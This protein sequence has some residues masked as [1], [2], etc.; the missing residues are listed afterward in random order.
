MGRTLL[1]PTVAGITAACIA[2]AWLGGCSSASGPPLPEKFEERSPVAG[3]HAGPPVDQ[4]QTGSARFVHALLDAYDAE[5]A[6]GVAAFLDGFYRAPASRGYEES[7]ERVLAALYGA[8]F[9]GEGGFD[10]AVARRPMAAA[11]WT[12]VSARLAAVAGEQAVREAVKRGMKRRPGDTREFEMMRFDE[13]R[14]LNRVMLPVGAPSC[15]LEGPLGLGLDGVEPG[16]VL[17]TDRPLRAVEQAAVEAGAIAIISDYVFPYCVDPT[18]EKRDYDAVFCDEVRAGSTIPSFQVSQRVGATLR[19]AAQVGTRVRLEAK[20][21][22]EERPLR[23][24]L[25]TIE[26]AERPEEVV[27]IL[28]HVDG[29]GANDNAA[30]AAGVIE[31][32]L[33]MKRLIEAGTLDRPRRSVCFVFGTETGAG[34]TAMEES[35]GTPVAAIVADMI[36]ADAAKTGATCL[37]ERGWDPASVFPLPPDEHTPWSSAAPVPGGP[38]VP[39]GLSIICREALIDV[40]YAEVAR[41]GRAWTTGEHPWEGG[42]DQVSFLVDG[43]ASSLIWHFTDFT[44]H[45][46]LD[47]MDMVDSDELRRTAVAIG[48]AALAVA[49]ARPMDLERHLDTLNL[50]RRLR[51]DA[52]VREEAGPEAEELWKAWFKGARFWLK[53]LT[54]GEALPE[55]DP[56]VFTVSP[57]PEGDD[58]SEE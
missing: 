34:V 36:A 39:H 54:A 24:V 26:G 40:S 57:E 43:I 51:L 8:G 38:M 55:A 52:V 4:G 45:T 31:L 10:L 33:S 49:D 28:G 44:F 30:G 50:E 2:S 35:G 3:A 47:R 48:A 29:A 11:A 9:G 37:L 25:A 13:E 18:G 58:G 32:A 22:R 19:T 16:R 53:A 27:F 7:I 12:P 6:M 23:T 17:L 46:S 1:G 56:L 15:S 41:G 42:G 20:V 14:D 21:R 5:A